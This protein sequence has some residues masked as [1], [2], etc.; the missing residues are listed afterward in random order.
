MEDLGYPRSSIVSVVSQQSSAEDAAGR[1]E[2]DDEKHEKQHEEQTRQELGDRERR[3]SN[4]REPEQGRDEPNHKEHKR[5]MQHGH[6]PPLDS[7]AKAVPCITV[8]PWIPI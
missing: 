7:S 8:E 6:K 4:R 5:H 2:T 3:A 1:G